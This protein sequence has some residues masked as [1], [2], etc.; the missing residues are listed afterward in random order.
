LDPKCFTSKSIKEFEEWI[1]DVENNIISRPWFYPDKVSKV[2]YAVAWL[3][4][5]YHIQW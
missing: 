2:Q 4:G 5:D 3:D 1:E